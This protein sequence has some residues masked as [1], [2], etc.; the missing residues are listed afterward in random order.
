MS[1]ERLNDQ[2]ILCIEKDM[3]ECIDVDTIISNFASRDI[4]SKCFV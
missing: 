2:V 1:Q 3:I 4:L